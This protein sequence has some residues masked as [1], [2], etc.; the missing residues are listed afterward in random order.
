MNINIDEDSCGKQIM[1]YHAQILHKSH[2]RIF[3][4]LANEYIV[5]MFSQN[6]K[7]RLAYICTNQKWFWEQDTE[8]MGK[9]YVPNS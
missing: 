3:G 2:F 9:H 6:L 7:T 1:Y 8:L 5:D 4:R